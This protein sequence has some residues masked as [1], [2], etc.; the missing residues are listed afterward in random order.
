MVQPTEEKDGDNKRY[1]HIR[2]TGDKYSNWIRLSK[3]GA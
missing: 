3:I 1:T 2:Q